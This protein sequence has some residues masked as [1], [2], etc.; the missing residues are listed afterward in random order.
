MHVCVLFKKEDLGRQQRETA[1]YRHHNRENQ[2]EK[3][4]EKK[5]G[6]EESAQANT[7][8]EDGQNKVETDGNDMRG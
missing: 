6:S 8:W 4:G 3:R 1:L 2:V 7:L 5:M